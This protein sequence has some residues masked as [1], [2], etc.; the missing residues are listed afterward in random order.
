MTLFLI[1]IAVFGVLSSLILF[2]ILIIVMM[3]MG[4]QQEMHKQELQD[5]IMKSTK[6]TTFLWSPK[7]GKE[8]PF[9]D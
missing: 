4:A 2:S 6:Q 8:I 3:A 9:G 5:T 7:R 1:L